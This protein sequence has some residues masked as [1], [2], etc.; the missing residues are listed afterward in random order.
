[1]LPTFTDPGD[2]GDQLRWWLAHDTERAEASRL[3]R[4]AV[5]DRTF[6]NN[7]AQ[8]LRRLGV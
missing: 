6:T 1:V 2:F 3:A 4:L 7:A 8:M 5:A